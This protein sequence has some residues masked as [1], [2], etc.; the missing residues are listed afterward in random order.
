MFA[1]QKEE[2]LRP[3]FSVRVLDSAKSD[4]NTSTLPQLLGSENRNRPTT[5]IPLLP[6]SYRTRKNDITIARLDDLDFLKSELSVDRLNEIHEWLMIVG[7]PMPPR[8][9]HLQRMKLR[10][11]C[12][13]EQMDLHLAWSPKR[14]Y[15]K[16]IPRFLLDTGFWE[17]YLCGNPRLYECAMGFLVSYT[18]LIQHESDFWIAK[19]A[20][21]LPKEVAWPQWVFLV[22]QLLDCRNLDNINKRYNY[23]ELRLGRLNMIYRFRKG[24]YRGYLSSCTTYGDFFRD[25]INSLITLFAYTT[26]VLSA[27]QVGLGTSYSQ[28]SRAFNRAS[29]GF[30]IFSI[31]APLISVAALLVLLIGLVLNNLFATMRYRRHKFATSP[32]AQVHK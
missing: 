2:S 6:A 4:D 15:V 24:R 19:D 12:P 8:A 7:R 10:E 14:I 18:A 23:G 30:A 3:P 1:S 9:L 21:L 32:Q 25:N 27:M 22:R 16:P 28:D 5:P 13:T 26:I 17:A 29:Y 31:I 11:I 20:H